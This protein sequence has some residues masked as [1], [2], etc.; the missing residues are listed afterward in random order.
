MAT[1]PAGVSGWHP[2]LAQRR[3]IQLH[4]TTNGID[5]RLQMTS[6]KDAATITLGYYLN[7]LLPNMLHIQFTVFLLSENVPQSTER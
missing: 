1:L 7:C 2:P 6:D 3:L 5:N 4:L